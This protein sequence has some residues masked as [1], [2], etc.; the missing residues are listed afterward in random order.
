MAQLDERSWQKEVE[1]FKD[2]FI[3]EVEHA[4]RLMITGFEKYIETPH[5]SYDKGI[6]AEDFFAWL[7]CLNNV[8]K[9]AGQIVGGE[10]PIEASDAEKDPGCDESSA[11]VEKLRKEFSKWVRIDRET[12]EG[13]R[14]DRSHLDEM[15]RF[16]WDFRQNIRFV[17]HSFEEMTEGAGSD[18]SMYNHAEVAVEK[19]GQKKRVRG[20]LASGFFIEEEDAF[21]INH[22]L[23]RIIAGLDEIEDC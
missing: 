17:C 19:N 21:A 2:N 20:K 15:D 10:I 16:L 22:L 23:D 6:T 11:A 3:M 14:K 12:L 8:N 18:S 1:A 13:Y 9:G 4:T 5:N 7:N